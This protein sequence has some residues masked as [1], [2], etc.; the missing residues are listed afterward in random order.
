M[1][2]NNTYPLKVWALC[3][4]LGPIPLTIS[5]WVESAKDLPFNPL[6]FYGRAFLAA[7]YY[8][9][10]TIILSYFVYRLLIKKELTSLHLK[11]IMFV[12]GMC[13]FSLT[14]LF[15][16]LS[17]PN[18]RKWGEWLI[19]PFYTILFTFGSFYF[20]VKKQ[21]NPPETANT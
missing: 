8:S 15:S 11:L 21:A 20:K 6:D 16:E 3:M 18:L 17:S 13:L 7:F 14:I 2:Y 12:V 5:W 10:P 1:P 9:I 4:I 19:L